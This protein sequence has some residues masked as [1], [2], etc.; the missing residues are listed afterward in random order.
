M[1]LI[2]SYPSASHTLRSR[3]L[4]PVLLP[5]ALL[6]LRP[7]SDVSEKRKTWDWRASFQRKNWI[8]GWMQRAKLAACTNPATLPTLHLLP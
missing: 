8:P 7:K 1:Y 6:K 2:S 3:N 5:R 4:D